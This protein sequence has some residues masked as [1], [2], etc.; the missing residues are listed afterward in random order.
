M[1]SV[2][3][4]KKGFSTRGAHLTGV[5]IC[6]RTIIFRYESPS[7]NCALERDMMGST[8]HTAVVHMLSHITYSLRDRDV[9]GAME[10]FSEKNWFMKK[11]T[12]LI[13][14]N[15]KNKAY[16]KSICLWSEIRGETPS[17]S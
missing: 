6:L 3:G 13:M 1:H 9:K 2:E 5:F 11:I 8:V 4:R 17:F 14:S 7:S 16:C 15:P 12:S 10:K